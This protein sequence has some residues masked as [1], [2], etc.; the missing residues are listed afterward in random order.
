MSELT[1]QILA[2]KALARKRLAALPIEEKFL[3][4]EKL[5]D[6]GR[7]IAQSSSRRKSPQSVHKT[8]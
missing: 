2:D 3:I 8:P 4:L 5:R 1:K 7:L 6:R